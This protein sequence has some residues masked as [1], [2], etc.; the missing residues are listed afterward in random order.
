MSIHHSTGAYD[1]DYDHDHDYD[2]NHDYNHDYEHKDDPER[3]HTQSKNEKQ[4]PH[5]KLTALLVVCVMGHRQ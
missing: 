2:H 3:A 4:T 5:T 1:N